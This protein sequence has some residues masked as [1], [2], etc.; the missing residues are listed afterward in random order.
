M[1]PVSGVGFSDNKCFTRLPQSRRP[2]FLWLADGSTVK[3]DKV[4]LRQHQQT[5]IDPVGMTAYS[6]GNKQTKQNK[7]LGANYIKSQRKVKA[8][9]TRIKSLGEGKK[10][11]VQFLLSQSAAAHNS[12][13]GEA[14]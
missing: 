5:L 9:E 10:A 4:R 12:N 2:L 1:Q 6:K 14:W 8:R 7:Q 3:S 13:R 11:A